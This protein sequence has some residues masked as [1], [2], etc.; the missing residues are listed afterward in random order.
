MVNWLLRLAALP[1][2]KL[3]AML[4]LLWMPRLVPDP[5]RTLQLGLEAVT[6]HTTKQNTTTK[7]DVR[8]HPFLNLHWNR[9]GG[10]IRNKRSKVALLFLK[11]FGMMN[12][13]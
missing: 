11:Q 4:P 2:Y 3:L 9:L 5:C 12:D 10:G 13:K 7:R 6:Q 8:V 1:V